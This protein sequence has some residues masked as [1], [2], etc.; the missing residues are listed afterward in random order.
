MIKKF[1]Q[2]TTI[3]LGLLISCNLSAQ[4]TGVR[5]L[6]KFD[7]TNCLYNAHI[8]IAS[9]SAN[10]PVQRAQFNAQ[11][12]LV[13]P[14]SDSLEIVEKF[15]PLQANQLYN[16]TVPLDW[17]ISSTRF[18]P[19][20]QPESNFFSIV[21]SLSPVSHYYNLAAGDTVKLFSL[22]VLDRVTMN[23]SWSCGENIRFFINGSDPG[24]DGVCMEGGDFSNGFTLGGLAQLYMENLPHIYPPKPALT[25]DNVCSEDININLSYYTPACQSPATFEWSGPGYASTTQDVFIPNAN[26][27]NNGSYFV[28]VTD[29]LGCTSTLEIETEV[30]PDAGANQQICGSGSVFISGS[31]NTGTWE[32]DSSN[33]P[34]ASLN[35]SFGGNASVNF[36]PG[37]TGNY[38]FIFSSSLCKDTMQISVSSALTPA[39]L[40]EDGICD[41]GSTILTASGGTTYVWSNGSN[42]STTTANSSGLYTVTVTG[43]GGCTAE[44]SKFINSNPAPSAD[45]SGDDNICSGES[46]TLTASGGV[47]Y[48]WSNSSVNPEITVTTGNNYSVT[49]TDANGCTAVAS[50]NVD[51]NSLPNAVISG[52]DGLCAG[53]NVTLTAS[54]GSFYN[55][56]TSDNT[57]SISTNM[58]GNYTVTVTD[59]NGCTDVESKNI[60]IFPSPTANISGPDAVCSGSSINLTAS[61]GISYIWSNAFT[62]PDITISTTD[63]YSVTVTDANGCT[64]EANKN[65]SVNN[66]PV[67]NI[68]GNN[69]ICSG[70]STILTASGGVSYLWSTGSTDSDITVSVTDNYSV[71]VTDANGCTDESNISLNVN[72]SPTAS[73]TG[74]NTICTGENSSFTAL[75]GETYLWGGGQ[76]TSAISVSTA[77]DY[78]VTVTDASGCT[79]TGTRTLTIND[80]PT[81]AITGAPEI[82]SGGSVNWVASGGATYLW[83]TTETGSTI[84]VST[85]GDYDVT[86]TDANG[87]T[88]TASQTLTISAAPTASITGDNAICAGETSSF[89]ALGGTSYLWNTTDTD[90]TITVSTAGD[91]TVT[92]TDASGCTSTGT[93]TL[94][95]NDN[96][97]AS[98]TGATEICSGGSVNWVASGGATYLWSTTETGSTIS[99]STAGDYDV[100]VTDANGCTST[101]SQTLTISAAPTASITGDNAICAG[102]TS[103]FTALGG[104]SYLWSTTDTDATITVSTA[105]DYTVTVTDASGCTS[106]GTRTL[107]INDNPTASITGATEICSGVA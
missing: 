57:A 13:V 62:T 6:L 75:G 24:S 85:A 88:S 7:T 47:S 18:A 97:T 66:L 38:Q 45:I 80:N 44:I 89:T 26:T 105:G 104:T 60:T 69:E 5:Y 48:L 17:V 2:L 71:T 73:I 79:S 35:P 16:G 46:T 83:S 100:T 94:T 98:I 101:A 1:T 30:K 96:P 70:E 51:V 36:T 52:S 20:D 55:W 87:C 43:T 31:P 63:N 12:T 74:D 92:V 77:G 4:V 67:A 3:V 14:T 107:T 37:S 29:A 40:G 41:G 61:G 84:S 91:Y 106:T 49:V 64:D 15:M 81:A 82:C 22:R 34:G 54:G 8:V 27:S 25:F 95:I 103:S 50:R 11:L 65:I 90:A 58:A 9:G 102:E 76:T 53:E 10:T 39:I 21:P 56:S 93:R 19:C 86:V 99:V 32:A 33:P 42:S 28:T 78:F 23:P 68:S 72:P 59:A